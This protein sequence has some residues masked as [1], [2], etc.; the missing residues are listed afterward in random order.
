MFSKLIYVLPFI[1]LLIFF[2]NIYFKG[3][4]I[5]SCLTFVFVCLPLMS[6]K[7]TPEKWGAFTVFDVIAWYCALILYKDFSTLVPK[8]KGYWFLFLSLVSIVLLG[9][10][11]S[12]FS[13]RAFLYTLKLFPIFI[14]ARCIVIECV[15]NEGFHLKIINSLKISYV[16]ALVFL[17]IQMVVGLKFTFYPELGPNTIDPIVHIIRYPGV[18]YDSQ[19]SGQYLCIGCFL[20]LYIPPNTSLK[21]TLL[22]YSVFFAALLATIY[23]GSR[24]AFGGLVIGFLVVFIMSNAR[25]KL[26]SIVSIISVAF[27]LYLNS[28][29]VGIFTRSNTLSEDYL[30]RQSLW[31][32]A[33]EIAKKHIFLGIGSGNYQ[34]YIMKYAQEQYLEI[35]PGEFLYF[36][37][38]ENG[39]LKILVEFGLIGFTIFLMFII[40]P[41]IQGVAAFIK[42]A[43]SNNISFLIAGVLCWLVA[44]NTVYSIADVRILLIVVTLVCLTL[45]YP[46]QKTIIYYDD[47]E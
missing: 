19:A 38:P 21:L 11:F 22:N 5:Q 12:E 16:I 35:L 25:F 20:F 1:T 43:V 13:D 40:F 24:S 8:F 31:V 17:F 41:L 34:P 45:T 37:Q 46:T 4:T 7:V 10:L 32:E 18:F 29:N 23:A 3:N 14:I 30:F 2:I 47:A 6:L 44:F 26:L 27:L 15:Q 42:G 36:D 28:P 39:Y 33:Y 9:G